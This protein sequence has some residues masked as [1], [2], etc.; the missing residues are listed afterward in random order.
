MEAPCSSF[1]TSSLIR[2][3]P[4]IDQQQAS[5]HESI[6]V[7]RRKY[8]TRQLFVIF[9][10][11][12]GNFF[13]AACVSLQA[14]FFPREAEEKGA[15]ATE[16]GFVFGV[17][18][19]AIIVISP[20]VGKLVGKMSSQLLIQFGLVTTGVA[21]ILFGFIDRLPAGK[22]F[23]I[24]AYIIRIIEGV[25]AS[26]FTTPSYASTAEEFPNDQATIL[27]FLET[28][29]GLGLIF[30]PTMGGWLYELG[31]YLLPFL[32]LGL[33]LFLGALLNLATALTKPSNALQGKNNVNNRL[34]TNNNNN[35]LD[36]QQASYSKI[37]FSRGVLVYALSI[38]TS[39]TVIGFNAATLEPHLRQFDLSIVVVGTIFVING[40]IYA[41][42]TPFCGY[43]CDRF[44]V[45]SL[46]IIGTVISLVGLVF[47]GPISIIPMTTKLEVVIAAL[48]ATGLGGAFKLF[49]S[50]V[51]TFKYAVNDLAMPDN[52]S[53]F[54]ICSSIYHTA[55]SI[56][57]LIGPS[58]G[59]MLVEN[60]GY[61]HA[62]YFLVAF[63]AC[64]LLFA[65]L[66]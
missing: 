48:V 30:G 8:T 15:T 45:N 38:V 21:T 53:T 57:A 31:G 9:S 23:I 64:L 42:A 54:G 27:S 7:N 65:V 26:S 49:S 2:H 35:N 22:P 17:Y 58:I 61:R 37:L 59:G 19:I 10:Y 11:I 40:T 36:I 34:L 16:Y 47:I 13:L 43:L 52:K 24:A 28:A 60:F 62:T 32:A 18:E 25:G 33:C 3:R 1:K 6:R 5:F 51:G 55:T 14:P 4:S 41:I 39:L 63:E 12:Y 66:K 50:L 20:I 56:G 29:F 46:L 44:N